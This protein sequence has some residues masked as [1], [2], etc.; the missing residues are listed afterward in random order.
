MVKASKE[1]ITA[2]VARALASK[3][4]G[5]TYLTDENGHDI[6]TESDFSLTVS[7]ENGEIVVKDVYPGR[8]YARIVIEAKWTF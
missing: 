2:A 1:N 5:V 7:E 3:L 6:T 8:I 4:Q